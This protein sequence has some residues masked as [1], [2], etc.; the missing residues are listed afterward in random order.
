M[1]MVCSSGIWPN[2][3]E[4]KKTLRSEW[5][6]S[7]LSNPKNTFNLVKNAGDFNFGRVAHG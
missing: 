6:F 4:P 5:N 7:K 2:T 3:A 1:A